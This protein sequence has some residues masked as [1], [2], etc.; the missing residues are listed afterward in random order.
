MT[1][2]IVDRQR[3]QPMEIHFIQFFHSIP[4]PPPRSLLCFTVV[5][6]LAVAFGCAFR[7]RPRHAPT[8]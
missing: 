5:R 1:S 3:A 8:S 2:V 6:V 4:L 7:V